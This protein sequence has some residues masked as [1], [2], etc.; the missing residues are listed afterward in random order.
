MRQHE[1]YEYEI[2]YDACCRS[3]NEQY[4]VEWANIDLQV[5][6]VGGEFCGKRN[7]R[8]QLIIKVLFKGKMIC[9]AFFF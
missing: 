1:A 3:G 6:S 9:V 7:G 5:I 4:Q 2:E 8:L